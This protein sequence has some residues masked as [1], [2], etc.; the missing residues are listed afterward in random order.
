MS[1]FFSE[2]VNK[3]KNLCKY[4][5]IHDEKPWYLVV[6]HKTT[7]LNFFYSWT[8]FFTLGFWE[9]RRSLS[10]TPLITVLQFSK[11]LK[12]NT[13]SM[14]NNVDF[15]SVQQDFFFFFFDST[16][17]FLNMCTE[18][19]LNRFVLVNLNPQNSV[20]R[21]VLFLRFTKDIAIRVLTSR[22]NWNSV[23]IFG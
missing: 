4:T 23:L 21:K 7:T 13:F 3:V 16:D 1:G 9:R 18:F 14:R 2:I 15:F 17:Q 11:I 8:V 10:N 19:Q 12:N 22:L 5:R 20:I 6:T